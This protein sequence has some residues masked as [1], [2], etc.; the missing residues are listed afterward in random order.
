MGVSFCSVVG[1]WWWWF[2]LEL[3]SAGAQYMNAIALPMPRSA[4][5][6]D[7]KRQNVPMMSTIKKMVSA[8]MVET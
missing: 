1:W 3:V 7:A 8:V 4:S 2:A 6:I 5:R